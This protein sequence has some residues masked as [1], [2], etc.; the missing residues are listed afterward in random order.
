MMALDTIVREA[1]HAAIAAGLIVALISSSPMNARGARD[2]VPAAQ[3]GGVISGVVSTTAPVPRPLRVTF[4]QAVCGNEVPDE[5]VLVD[6][7][8]RLANAVITVSGA[9]ATGTPGEPAVVNEKCRFFPHVQVARPNSKVK[10]SSKDPILHTTNAHQEGGRNLF[11]LGLPAPGLTIVRP[12]SGAG[13]VRLSCNTHPWMLAWIFVTADMA[14]V[15]GADGRFAIA[16]VPPGTYE[17]RFWHEALKA[18]SRKVSVTAG[19]KTEIAV[20]MK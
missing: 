5:S 18:A 10:T 20:E 16:D 3:T 11:N 15:T 17:L 1:R 12:I 4:D 9:R 19:E 8:G 14:A 7:A 6:A 13:V 2:G